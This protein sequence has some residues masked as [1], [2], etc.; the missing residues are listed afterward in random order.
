M[1]A[2]RKE[3]ISPSFKQQIINS[4][5]IECILIY[6]EDLEIYREIKRYKY[7]EFMREYRA[8][9]KDDRWRRVHVPVSINKKVHKDK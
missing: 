1:V 6:K 2:K 8:L 4:C 9:E 7:N 3:K 5:S